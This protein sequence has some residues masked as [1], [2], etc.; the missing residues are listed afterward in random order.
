MSILF[1][2]INKNLGHKSF[3][4]IFEAEDG[5]YCIPEEGD[6]NGIYLYKFNSELKCFEFVRKILCDD[7]YVDS[8]IHNVNGVYYLFTSTINEPFKQRLFYS[9]S[10]LND[11]V[12]HKMS[13]IVKTVGLGEMEG[14]CFALM[15]S[16]TEYLKTVLKHMAVVLL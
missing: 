16:Y 5:L 2:E 6:R 3:P 15:I 12:E 4:Y 14:V 10:L 7:M 9:D 1:D 13:P 11:F 8:F